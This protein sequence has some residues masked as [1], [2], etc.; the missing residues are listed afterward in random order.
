MSTMSSSD[1]GGILRGT[2]TGKYFIE[3]DGFLS[4]HLAHGV[5]ALRRLGASSERVQQFVDWYVPRLETSDYDKLDDR[6]FE[7]LKGERT[8]FY[9]I[10]EEYERRLSVLNND[11]DRLIKQ[12][13]PSLSLG[14]AGSALHGTIHLGY[15]YSAGHVKGV[16]EGLAYTFHSYRPVISSKT[17]Q[18]LAAFGSGTVD[19]L[20]VLKQVRDDRELCDSIIA[21]A[22]LEKYTSLKLGKFQRQI[23][24]L[25]GDR[26][27]DIWRYV[28]S[29]MVP[30]DIKR[31]D[32]GVDTVKLARRLVYWSVLCYVTSEIR[33]HFFLLHG[34]TCAWS[35]LQIVPILETP[36]AIAA[37]R[38][39]TAVL[40]AVYIACK[41]PE[42]RVPVTETTV[43]KESWEALINR[44]FDANRDEH[45]YKLLQVCR[46]MATDSDK[47]GENAA[48]YYQAA[49]I[50]TDTDDFSY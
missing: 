43:D 47:F 44:Q 35:L 8:G 24:Y 5:I 31:P 21:G 22:E 23:C 7:D 34:V 29:V 2:D 49:Q 6:P 39:F 19:V 26:G 3:Y 15:C 9:T 41:A 27:D 30:T 50:T 45:C 14:L 10:L 40:V 4:N 11:V 12:G 36:D 28:L 38:N 42:L 20:D 1:V 32:G 18:D 46:D 13:Y 48:L 17:D 33:N 25:L 16:L 37:C